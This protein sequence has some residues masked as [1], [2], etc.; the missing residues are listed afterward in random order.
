LAAGGTLTS[1]IPALGNNSAQTLVF[2][3]HS[4]ANS[5]TIHLAGSGGV[6]DITLTRG[7][8]TPTTTLPQVPC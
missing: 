6:D 1:A 3:G 4:V 8:S 7:G 5:M 2:S